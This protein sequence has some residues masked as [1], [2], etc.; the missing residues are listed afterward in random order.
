MN[1]KQLFPAL[2]FLIGFLLPSISFAG[3][4]PIAPPQLQEGQFVYS[5]GNCA[6]AGMSKNQ[7]NALN[8]RLKNLHNPFYVVVLC[9][10]PRMTPSM[11]NYARSNGFRG[12]SEAKRIET[13][14]AMLMEDWA[15]EQPNAYDETNAG[16]FVISFKPRKYAW[17]PALR[18]K[19]ELRLN[20][21]G[22]DQFTQKFV[23]SAKQ[24]PADYGSGIG[25]LAT[26]YDTWYYDRTDPVRIA[27]R[28]EATRLR[29]KQLRLQAAQGALDAEIL[30][31]SSLLSEKEY[32]PDDVA[33]YRES[34][35]GAKQIR[36]QGT[37]EAMD[38][39]ADQLKST[40]AVLDNYVGEQRSAARIALMVSFLKWFGLSALLALI[41]F[42]FRRR[43][44]EQEGL[45]DQWTSII[46][47][48]DTKVR[49]AHGRWTDHYLE[50]EDVIG[51][52]GVSGKTKELWDA[53]TKQVDDLLVRIRAMQ[54]HQAD[55]ERLYK[56]G[57]FL[58][59]EAYRQAI[60]T[61]ERPFEFDT[62]KMNE[63]DLF[64][65]ETETL[66]VTPVNFATEASALFSAS[67]DGWKR[68]QKAAE[69]RYGE[70][71]EDF[72]HANM[73]LLFEMAEKYQIPERWLDSHP[74]YGDDDSDA[75]FY[76][77]LDTLRQNDPLAYVER[78]K[79][80]RK[81]EA[82]KVEQI[83]SFVEL[84]ER[85]TRVRVDT[86]FET[87]ATHVSPSDDPELT[88][89]AA[90]Q[91]EDK[92]AGIFASSTEDAVY[93]QAAAVINLYEETIRQRA[94]IQSA[95]RGAEGAIEDAKAKGKAALRS[96]S[97]AQ[98]E[99][100]A[101][102]KVHSRTQA[103]RDDLL[104]AD[105]FIREGASIVE[106]AETAFRGAHHLDARRLADRASGAFQTS[107]QRSGEA[108][109]HCTRLD[110]EKAKYEEKLMSI[111]NT[112]KSLGRKMSGYG[113]YATKLAPAK[114]PTL[115]GLVD[116][117]AVTGILDQQITGWRRTVRSSESNYEDEQ[118]RQR[119]AYEQKKREE[120]K[121][122]DDERR[123]RS[124][125]SSSYSSSS[126]SSYG[127]GGFGGSSGGFGGGGFGGSSGSF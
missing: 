93:A 118:R 70:A 99:L 89:A 114:K 73:D 90:R 91:A 87:A 80:V 107:I 111:D 65:G 19:N 53:T 100:A 83:K 126:S 71:S 64:G 81:E 67:L 85:I 58:N 102:S 68:L 14:T 78:I 79:E 123:R 106:E 30:H 46:A 66:T 62:G 119:R 69:E 50:R 22:Q 86:P 42:L 122:Q 6:P 117:A 96:K 32:L 116:Y 88:L 45:I 127:G 115:S 38:N 74:L 7:Q 13:T 25:N 101:A 20:N 47:D 57:G 124:S 21:R 77:T 105:R 31:L 104:A 11:T 2:L 37:P 26:S 112:R 120:Q 39:Q 15:T 51:L 113:S 3:N 41:V 28:Q 44:R 27:Q 109:G 92:L 63:A 110:A 56:R 98:V 24:R 1:P 49:N 103:A 8:G 84:R 82:V 23:R 34:L 59:F 108:S 125:Y 75:V 18:A 121:R 10:L 54:A 40:V 17:H 12:D 55:C 33:S 48:W 29:Q 5:P 60:Q 76:A 72:P 95:I 35:K 9:D 61:F 94:E 4:G 16:V 36:K 43:R 52:D 97:E